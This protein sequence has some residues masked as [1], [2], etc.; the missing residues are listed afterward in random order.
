MGSI[1]S[2]CRKYR[3][4]V[5]FKKFLR[6]KTKQRHAAIT[7]FEVGFVYFLIEAFVVFFQRVDVAC[8]A[9]VLV[10][11]P[12]FV[13]TQQI[14]VCQLPIFVLPM[15]S[16]AFPSNIYIPSHAALHSPVC[17]FFAFAHGFHCGG[18][19]G[20]FFDYLRWKNQRVF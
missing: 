4:K 20:H 19:C 11:K 14:K 8:S 18:S 13:T 6:L 16:P 5:S 3:W 1:L 10:N 9:L 15:S 17:Q 2:K 7:S 12:D